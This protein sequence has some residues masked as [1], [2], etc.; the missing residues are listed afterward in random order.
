M[1]AQS[2]TAAG[3]SSDSEDDLADPMSRILLHED[4]RLD[5]KEDEEEGSKKPQEESSAEQVA[6]GMNSP[7]E[8]TSSLVSY[9]IRSGSPPSAAAVGI[10]GAPSGA[11]VLA[12]EKMQLEVLVREVRCQGLSFQIWPAA[13][14]LCWYLEEMVG[15]GSN[16]SWLGLMDK[17]LVGTVKLGSKRSRVR[18]LE[19][20]AGTGM[21]GI[22]CA[23]LGADCVLTDLSHVTPNLMH[24]AALNQETIERSGRGGSISVKTL[25]WGDV[26][27]MRIVGRDFNLVVASDVVYYDHLFEPLLH[28]LKWLTQSTQSAQPYGLDASVNGVTSPATHCVKTNECGPPVVLLAHLRRW[29]KDSQFFK[30][31]SKLFDVTVAH[32]HP[33]TADARTG[34]TVYC[35][36]RKRYS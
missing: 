35:L 2:F 33:H 24:N 21:V 9:K 28:T 10:M 15:S 16:P 20:G 19:L 18:V 25:R 23:V 3:L 1:L 36:S 26:D 8:A 4:D 32:K 31:A 27:D 22:V 13:H 6:T 34:V 5:N 7:M 29:K 12:D 17:N 30:K 14:A 11:G